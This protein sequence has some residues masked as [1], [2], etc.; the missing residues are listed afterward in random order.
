MKKNITA[1]AVLIAAALSGCAATTPT[2][3][4]TNT[5]EKTATSAVANDSLKTLSGGWPV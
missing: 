3:T 2:T 5:V 4:P 1:L